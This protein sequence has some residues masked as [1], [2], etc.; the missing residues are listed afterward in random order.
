MCIDCDRDCKFAQEEDAKSTM[1]EQNDGQFSP[2]KFG[3]ADIP[4]GKDDQS[5]QSTG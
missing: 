3:K 1:G 2:D 5:L 4:S